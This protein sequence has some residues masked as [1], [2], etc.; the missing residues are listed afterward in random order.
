MDESRGDL[1][2]P[3]IMSVSESTEG[4]NMETL[5]VQV[6]QD[7]VWRRND[8]KAVGFTAKELKANSKDRNEISR[9]GR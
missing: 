8:H 3:P 2:S 1:G 5:D 4:P 6:R 7:L 9:E